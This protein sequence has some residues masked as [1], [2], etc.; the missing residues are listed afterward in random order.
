MTPAPIRLHNFEPGRLST[1][2]LSREAKAMHIKSALYSRSSNEDQN[3]NGSG[4]LGENTI[5]FITL[6]V[7]SLL[8]ILI[9]FYLVSRPRAASNAGPNL[10]CSHLQHS[11]ITHSPCSGCVR[12]TSEPWKVWNIWRHTRRTEPATI[13][14]SPTSQLSPIPAAVTRPPRIRLGAKTYPPIVPRPSQSRRITS[15]SVA[16]SFSH[17]HIT[18]EALS[19]FCA[20]AYELDGDLETEMLHSATDDVWVGHPLAVEGRYGNVLGLEEV[21]EARGNAASLMEGCVEGDVP[22]R[23]TTLSRGGDYETLSAFQGMASGGSDAAEEGVAEID[24]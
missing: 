12:G 1:S 23:L 16:T 21:V 7:V 20:S 9:G 6:G 17:S 10:P 3:S 4:G 2:T 13:T 19:E 14:D 5:I 18:E 22:T 24:N 8:V 11:S 15:L